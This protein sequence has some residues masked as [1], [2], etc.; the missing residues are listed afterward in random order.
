MGIGGLAQIVWRSSPR[1]SLLQIEMTISLSYTISRPYLVV[2]PDCFDEGLLFDMSKSPIVSKSST[3]AARL[4]V[5]PGL[6][7]SP[8]RLQQFAGLRRPGWR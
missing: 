6:G 5:E 7:G 2:G 4:L 1:R 3:R 8:P